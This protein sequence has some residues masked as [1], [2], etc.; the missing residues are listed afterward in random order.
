M[1]KMA[2]KELL[3]L[4]TSGGPPGTTWRPPI[5]FRNARDWRL[6]TYSRDTYFR[7]R[8]TSGSGPRDFRSRMRTP[9]F[10]HVT[11][12]VTSGSG[13]RDF[14]SVA[15]GYHPPHNPPPHPPPQNPTPAVRLYYSCIV[16]GN[17]KN[18]FFTEYFVFGGDKSDG[19][20]VT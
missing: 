8:S 1:R 17:G 20:Y 2:G 13:T 15:M 4:T 10:L 9:Y 5:D 7:F 18:S 16:K 3:P 14:R 12:D 11:Y 19:G 6:T